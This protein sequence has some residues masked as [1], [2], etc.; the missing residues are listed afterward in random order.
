MYALKSSDVPATGTAYGTLTC[1]HDVVSVICVVAV[2]TCVL[3]LY[4]RNLSLSTAPGASARTHIVPVYVPAEDAF[5]QF[6]ESLRVQLVALDPVFV[7][8]AAQ[9][10]VCPPETRVR[11]V[12]DAPEFQPERSVSNPGLATRFPVTTTWAVAVEKRPAVSLTVTVTV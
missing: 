8:F 5:T 1:C 12:V 6:G 7:S 9:E 3:P 2:P 10:P 4:S 11:G